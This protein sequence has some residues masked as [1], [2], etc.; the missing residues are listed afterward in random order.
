VSVLKFKRLSHL[1]TF[2]L[3]S[4]TTEVEMEVEVEVVMEVVME[5]EMTVT[6]PLFRRCVSQ[7][8]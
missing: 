7:R 4:S 2:S 1:N 3:L 6:V 5:M 8:V